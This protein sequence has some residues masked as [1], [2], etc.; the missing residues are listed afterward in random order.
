MAPTA[1]DLVVKPPEHCP[2]TESEQA[3]KAASCEG[4]P[5]QQMCATGPKGPDPAISEIADLGKGGVGKSTFTTNLSFALS[6]D[7]DVQVGVLDVDICGPSLAKM[8]GLEG[9][10]IH[11]SNSGWTPVYVSDN[12]CVMSI[13]FL[14]PDQNDAIIWRGA[15]KMFLKDV[16]WGEQDYLLVDT[17]PGTSDEHL[18]IV[19]Y[20]KESGIDGAIVIT[21][22][23][24]VSLQDVRKEL[25]FCKKVG[26]KVLGVVEN[27]AAFVCPKCDK[28]SNV[29]P[30]TSGGARKLAE[31]FGVPFWDRF[32]WIPRIGMS[33]DNG[34]SFLDEFRDSPATQAYLKI[35]EEVRKALD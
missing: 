21:T 16:D 26:I 12:L 15:K 1:D 9:E 17:P 24:E 23:Q 8:T 35:V 11:Q 30:A 14:L 19:T 34:R 10:P 31:D 4:C 7:E 25:N 6:D 18:S 20:L 29:F 22:P 33:C 5:N 27:M 28:T 32:R 3:G 2:G 13:A